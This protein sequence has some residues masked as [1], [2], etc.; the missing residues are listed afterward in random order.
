MAEIY[1]R[2]MDEDAAARFRAAA[3]VRGLT[4]AEYANRLSHLHEE[5]RT[6][7]D[8]DYTTDIGKGVANLLRSHLHA[9]G[10]ATV[11]G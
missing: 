9:L 5:M 4:W 8:G 7:A 3:R 1:I 6:L 2:N 11:V 10:L